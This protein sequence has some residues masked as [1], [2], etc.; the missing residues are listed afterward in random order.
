MIYNVIIPVIF[1]DFSFLNKTIRYVNRFLSPQKV[2]II[3][4]VKFRRFL[5]KEILS[6]K[7]C[8]VIDENK[9]L[10]GLNI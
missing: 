5:P 4:D 3:T 7:N 10:D 9:V 8:V 2:Y 6:H 1:R